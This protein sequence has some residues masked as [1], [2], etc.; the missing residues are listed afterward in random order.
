MEMHSEFLGDEIPLFDLKIMGVY[1]MTE[2]GATLADALK[3]YSTTEK[4]YNDNVRRVIFD[5]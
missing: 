1:G 5:E 4:E 2:R 3:R